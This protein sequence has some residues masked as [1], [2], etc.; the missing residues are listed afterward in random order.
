[1][2][3]GFFEVIVDDISGLGSFGVVMDGLLLDFIGFS[4]EEVVELEGFVYL[5]DDF[6]ES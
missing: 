3:E 1:M 6:G 2:D 4:G 5:G